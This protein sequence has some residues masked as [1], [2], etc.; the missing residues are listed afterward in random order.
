MSSTSDSSQKPPESEQLPKILV[1]DDDEQ[2]LK[3]IRW[4]L[5]DQYELFTAS[6]R[7]TALEIARREKILVVLLDLGLPPQPREATEGLLVLEELLYVSP[8]A[9]V[10]IVSGNSERANAVRA[11]EKGAYD[12][13]PKPLEIDQLKIVLGRV[14][15][16]LELELES[17][18]RPSD[19]K[20]ML[21]EDFVGSSPQIQAVFSTIRK[22]AATDVPVLITGETGTGKE[23]VASAIHQLSPRKDQ[24]FVAINCGAIPENLLESE[25][26]GHEKG[27][28]TGAINLRRGKLEYAQGGTLFLDE[29]GELAH[30]LQ[31]K[32]LRFLQEHVIE[33]VGGHKPIAVECRVTAATNR[34]LEK[35]VADGKFR[36]DFYF[37]LAVVKIHL[38]PLRERGNDVR[39][40]AEHFASIY[41]RELRKPLKKLSER[42]V[43]ALLNHSWRGNV[44]ELQNRVR[45]SILFSEGPVIEPKDLELESAKSTRNASQ[46]SLKKAKEL[47]ESEL[48]SQALEENSG[49]ISKAARALGIS[50]PTLYDLMERYGL[51]SSG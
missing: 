46:T 26:F 3:Q 34:N 40:L 42:A 1:V 41:S 9:K 27:A 13:F 14:C 25:L 36:E 48:V 8:L 45:R 33:R 6:D 4:A 19:E 28:F 30:D 10:L 49:N 17:T 18:S 22:V 2:I 32:L 23:R 38:P 24:P 39:K 44:R 12:F 21:I 43:A 51:R 47:L 16:R 31:I 11:V 35:E 5:T 15:R 50:R 29:I 20:E 7:V 37:R